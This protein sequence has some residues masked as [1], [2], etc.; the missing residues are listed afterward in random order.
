MAIGRLDD[1]TSVDFLQDHA[2]LDGT[3]AVPAR[4][5]ASHRKEAMGTI[6]PDTRSDLA[7]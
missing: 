1:V 3:R 2:A 5:R 4:G 6:E 7:R